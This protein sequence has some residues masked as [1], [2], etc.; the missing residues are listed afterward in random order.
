[1]SA[2]S[3][4]TVAKPG[5]RAR[6][7]LL[8]LALLGGALAVLCHD[9]FKPHHVM[10]ANDTALGALD[11]SCA[12]LPATYTGVWLD[13]NWIGVK[14][15][16]SSPTLA[17]L[18]ATFISP[19]LYLKIFAPLTMLL[20]GFSA[21][22]L[23]RQLKF[24]PMVC[25]VGGL[26]AG[27][28][29]HCFSDASWGLGTWNI[30]L[31]MIFLALAALVSGSI[32]QTWIKAALAGLASRHGVWLVATADLGEAAAAGATEYFNSSILINPGGAVADVRQGV[33][34]A[35]AE[36]RRRGL[37][38]SEIVIPRPSRELFGDYL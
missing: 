13:L 30:A 16:S 17:T 23:F 15:P 1:M 38:V 24:A 9:G 7:W 6:H 36:V 31:A 12:R 21:W 25:V 28:N 32:R 22:V 29:M 20:L 26:G 18:L 19:E 34:V 10:W 8:L 33:Q 4:G 5:G 2:N 14:E 37:L 3:N 11:A 27:L 35:A